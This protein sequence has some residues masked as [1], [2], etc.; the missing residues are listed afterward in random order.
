L[1]SQVRVLRGKLQREQALRLADQQRVKDLE[2]RLAVNAS[3]SS[4]PPSANPRGAPKPWAKRPTGRKRGA[5]V[6]H[7]G[8]GRKLLPPEQVDERVEYRPAVCEHCQ[9]S[10]QQQ[11]GELVGRHQVAELPPR[12]VKITEHQSFA[13]RC[14][15]CGKV[16][17]AVIPQ[18][19]RCSSIGPRLCGAIG[20]LSALGQGSRRAVEGVVRDVLGCN[21]ALGSVSARERELSGALAG[22]YGEL[23]REVSAA[24][25]KYVDE[26]SWYCKS[27]EE[28][29][30]VGASD[31]AAVFRVEKTRT[32]SALKQLLCGQ[33]RGVFCTDRATIYDVLPLS[34]RG[35]CWAHLKRD[36]VRCQERGGASAAVGQAGLEV[37]QQVFGLWREF[38]EGRITR[39]ELQ[40]KVQ[41]LRQKMHAGL[42]KGADGGIAKTSGLCRGLLKRQEAMWNWAKVPGLQPTNNLAE[43]MLRPAVIWRKKSFGSDSRG[44]CVFAERMM[45]VI[46]TIKL[47]QQNVQEYL[48]TALVAHRAG[49]PVPGPGP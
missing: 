8:H 14:A 10:L 48:T 47:R 1:L 23:A 39:R 44:G 46:Q 40:G 41:P 6:G 2:E 21:I 5:Q 20:V 27:A 15:A 3:N 43:R 12:A 18:A 37:C 17:R 26:T 31:H 22:P 28:W 13:C 34:R 9:A 7:A 49:S 4:L 16:S 29:L 42:Q 38:R 19:V 25:V 30:F 24:R 32:R 45:S 33:L 36:F 35:V 11:A